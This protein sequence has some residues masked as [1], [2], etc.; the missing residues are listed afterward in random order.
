MSFGEVTGRR[1]FLRGAAA[2]LGAAAVSPARAAP[3]LPTPG[4]FRVDVDDLRVFCELRGAGAP[5]ILLNG[6]W[7]DSFTDH[8]GAPL[9]AALAG[10]RRVLT[11]DQRGQGR[12]TLGK[13]RVTYGRF[14]HDTVR[15]MD[16]LNIGQAHFIGHSDGGVVQLELLR[17]YPERVAS[18]T[19]LGTSFSQDSYRPS[20]RAMFTQWFEQMRS[21]ADVVETPH[22]LEKRARYERVSPEPQNFHAMLVAQRDCWATQ[23][24]FSLREL[25]LIRRP[26]LVFSAGRD[27][28][29]PPA[30]FDL[31][32]ASIPGAKRIAMPDMTHDIRPHIPQI[33]AAFVGFTNTLPPVAL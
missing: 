25:A 29:M 8:F 12:T 13:G 33:V 26:V 6:M 5:T 20:V 15:L 3:G 14:A 9:L 7:Q 22:Q 32:A 24:N 11:F 4:Q 16:R 2:A 17:D 18:A 30:Q 28:S 31:L 19:L 27:E 23:P 21:G 10:H 1:R